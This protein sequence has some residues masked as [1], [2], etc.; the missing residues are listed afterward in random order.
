MT[1]LVLK[2]PLPTIRNGCTRNEKI[3]PYGRD[4]MAALGMMGGNCGKAAISSPITLETV[5]PIETK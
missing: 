4:D 1:L 2:R 3:S 5:I